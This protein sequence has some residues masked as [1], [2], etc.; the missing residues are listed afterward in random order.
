MIKVT[1]QRNFSAVIRIHG[2]SFQRGSSSVYNPGRPGLFFYRTCSSAC[3][4]LRRCAFDSSLRCRTSPE[5]SDEHSYNRS[6]P[7][8]RCPN[9]GI[10]IHSCKSLERSGN[11]LTIIICPQ[12]NSPDLAVPRKSGVKKNILLLINMA[13]LISCGD[14]QERV[15]PTI[16]NITE[17]VYA[18]GFVKSKNQYEVYATVSGV[19]KE[20]Y[21][22]EGQLVK[23]GTPLLKLHNETSKLNLRNAEL[24]AEYASLQSNRDKLEESQ[25]AISL[26]RSKMTTDSLLCVRQQN[27]WQRNIGSKTELEQRQ[28]A[29]ENAVHT[30]RSAVIRYND[31]YRQ[32]DLNASQ[33]RN[34]LAI[35]SEIAE[36]YTVRS[37]VEGKVYTIL[38]ERGEMVT[39][40]T[41][42]A[43]VGDD[44]SFLLELQVDEHDIV[45]ISEKQQVLISMDSYNNQIFE[46]TISKI[47]PA[48]NERSQ[49]FTVEATFNDPP[50]ILYPFLTAEAN[51]IIQSKT[52]AITIPRSFLVDDEYVITED[53]QR[54]KITTG[55]KDYEK[56][57][58][59]GGLEPNEFIL[60]P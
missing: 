47:Y 60:K 52:D 51:I 28:L 33:S 45:R 24:A 3:R 57:E 38:K 19:I 37:E 48:M 7:L 21:V 18:A 26:A 58:V 41:P 53:K 30:Y 32:L 10:N 55:L 42:I 50:D 2:R 23:K 46:G 13:L 34:T 36:D 56:I 6:L 4:C 59:L 15:Q 25:L 29:Y 14:E 17:S 1:L 11:A 9:A 22:T 39:N 27:L 20:I 49:S 5:C 35:N 12:T 8:I 40:L 43:M 54:R 44:E 16:E 31:L